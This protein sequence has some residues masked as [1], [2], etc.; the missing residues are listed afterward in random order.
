ME[1]SRQTNESMRRTSKLRQIN[2]AV[3]PFPTKRLIVAVIKSGQG[4]RPLNQKKA[5]LQVRLQASAQAVMKDVPLL[6][7][8]S[9]WYEERGIARA[10][11]E[12]FNYPAA[13]CRANPNP[14]R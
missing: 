4:S 11:G 8:F 5:L 13:I 12:R 9:L 3:K 6:T 7:T 1:A 2:P 10:M 14:N